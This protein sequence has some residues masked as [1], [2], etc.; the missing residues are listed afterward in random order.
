MCAWKKRNR[1]VI[2]KIM[3]ERC[4]Y[5]RVYTCW[6]STHG[7]DMK[8]SKPVSGFNIWAAMWPTLQILLNDP[9]NDLL[10]KN[11]LNISSLLLIQ[12]AFATVSFTIEMFWWFATNNL[13]IIVCMFEKKQIFV[14]FVHFHN[15]FNS[16][17]S[18]DSL[19]NLVLKT[20]SFP[21]QDSM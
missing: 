7:L 1:S 2:N 9:V 19:F 6:T 16:L 17:P 4:R 18:L 11:Q 21:N 3:N 14:H 13:Q 15:I 5:C 8:C 20:K 10:C 12:S